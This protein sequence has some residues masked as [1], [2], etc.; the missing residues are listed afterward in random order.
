VAEEVEVAAVVVVAFRDSVVSKVAAVAVAVFLEQ[1]MVVV[2]REVVVVFRVVRVAQVAQV[3]HHHNYR[4]VTNYGR[5][6]TARLPR[7]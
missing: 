6:Y 4:R 5:P 2:F 7:T 1:E 3:I